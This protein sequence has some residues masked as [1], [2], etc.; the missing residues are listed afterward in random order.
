MASNNEDAMLTRNAAMMMFVILAGAGQALAAA[1]KVAEPCS[2][3]WTAGDKDKNG[4]LSRDEDKDNFIDKANSIS[5]SPVKSE[6][7]N[8][9]EFLSICSR[10]PPDRAAATRPADAANAKTPAPPSATR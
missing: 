7:L 5:T 10:N 3:L 9:D 2:A 6:T 1:E 4:V 8:R